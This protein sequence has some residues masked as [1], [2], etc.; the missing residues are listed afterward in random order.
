MDL[1]W[2]INYQGFSGPDK[3]RSILKNAN[4]SYRM[5]LFNEWTWRP[6]DNDLPLY[7]MREEPYLG[8]P[9]AY[10]IYMYSESEYEAAMKLVGSWN[11]W[12][13]L[14]TSQRFMEGSKDT[15]TW[16]GLKQ[17][18]EEKAIK[19]RATVYTMLKMAAASGNVNAQKILFEKD[20]NGT[21]GRPT[22]AQ[23]EQA[24]KEAAIHEEF[25]QEDLKR[26]RLVASNGS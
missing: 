1:N 17:W 8:Y 20:K 26:I 22:K 11:H 19:D 24:A 9:S 14:L 10:L 18:R 4:G 16:S 23:V 21:R 3:D 2:H 12:N 7:T 15:L 5:N 6:T 25:V 13:K